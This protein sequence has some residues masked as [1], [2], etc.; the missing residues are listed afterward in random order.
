[1]SQSFTPQIY[2]ITPTSFELEALLPK[3][4]TIVEEI[5]IACVRLA[6][7]ELPEDKI[8]QL[9]DNMRE[10]CHQH[11]IPVVLDEHFR[12]AQQI[13]LD[14]VHLRHGPR[15]LG[16]ARK[17]LGEDAIVGCFCDASSHMG[18]TAGENGADYVSFGPIGES[19]KGDGARAEKDLFQ[20]WSEMIEVPVVA[21]GAL[22]HP[23]V[24]ELSQF[25]DF[26]AVG[27]EIWEEENPLEALQTLL[28]PVFDANR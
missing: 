5:K 9:G 22:S 4:K 26:F 10:F 14:G 27:P 7:S 12:L 25:T 17:T 16:A 21:E 28:G 19:V 18:M 8:I 20:W 23:H 2:L 1:M 11:D 15:H 3:L 24:Q 6:I 13:G